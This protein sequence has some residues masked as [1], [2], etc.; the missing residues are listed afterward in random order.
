M[1]LNKNHQPIGSNYA[2]VSSVLFLLLRISSDN[3]P[4]ISNHHS[5]W[6]WTQHNK[7]CLS[8]SKFEI[9]NNICL[10]ITKQAE[11]LHVYTI[12]SKTT[13][14]IRPTVRYP[15]INF[16]KFIVIFKRKSAWLCLL[17]NQSAIRN[18]FNVYIYF[19]IESYLFL[20]SIGVFFK[21]NYAFVVKHILYRLSMVNC[22]KREHLCLHNHHV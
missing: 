9:F 15:L 1:L 5:P 13:V 17:R 11:F 8:K 3:M 21:N 20:W 2:G 22:H 19:K 4:L 7:Q 18:L 12:S 16:E 14:Y 6:N 10:L